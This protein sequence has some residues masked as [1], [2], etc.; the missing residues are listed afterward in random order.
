[1]NLNIVHLKRIIR[2]SN[3]L[4]DEKNMMAELKHNR[5]PVKVEVF[6][7]P[8]DAWLINAG[9]Y[10]STRVPAWNKVKKAF[11]ANKD[12]KEYASEF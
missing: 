2:V 12:G 1:M 3:S 4:S 6:Q 9:Y 5:K 10:K 8:Q 11:N 7:S